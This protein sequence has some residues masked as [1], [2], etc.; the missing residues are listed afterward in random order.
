[1]YSKFMMHGQENIKPSVLT[2]DAAWAS[3]PLLAFWR[4][5][6]FP[7]PAGI[8]DPD[9]SVTSSLNMNDKVY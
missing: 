1:M 3:Q 5:G 6:T 2:E 8:P 9:R 7:Q 4:T